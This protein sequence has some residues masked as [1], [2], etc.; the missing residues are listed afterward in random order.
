MFTFPNRENT[1][2]WPRRMFTEGI[3]LKNFKFKKFELGQP[4]NRTKFLQH[5][6]LHLG[7]WFGVYFGSSISPINGEDIKITGK[8]QGILP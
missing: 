4:N 7:L 1:G 8:T 3:Y 6:L 5:A 2:N